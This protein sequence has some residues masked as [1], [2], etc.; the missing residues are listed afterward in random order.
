MDMSAISGN[1]ILAMAADKATVGQCKKAL[2]EFG[3]L[4]LPVVGAL[5]DG[6]RVILSGECEYAAIRESGSQKMMAAIARVPASDASG[7]KLSLLLSSMRKGPGALCEGMLLRDALDSGASRVEI[8]QMLGRS[9]SW[10]SNRLAL[11]M[12]LDCGV[13]EM[14]AR[15]LIEA[16]TAQEIARL[17][18]GVQH[19]F[20]DKVIR[21][22]LP[23]SAVEL[24]VAGYRSED[25]PDEVKAQIIG[26]PCDA[27]ARM[28]DNRR[29]VEDNGHTIGK[30]DVPPPEGIAACLAA[31]KKPF[32]WLARALFNTSQAEA[33]PYKKALQELE[34]DVLSLLDMIHRLIPPGKLN[35]PGEKEEVPYVN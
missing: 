18:E 21:E 23:K 34:N 22:G 33:S 28:K 19:D 9:A 11:A 4:N 13:Q 35:L 2:D 27:L 24:L 17:P 26:N 25:C 15:G 31:A 16:R 7:A 10:L 1:K 32:A 30:S 29:A 6:S 20:A 5:V 14:L 12:R 8:G 3:A